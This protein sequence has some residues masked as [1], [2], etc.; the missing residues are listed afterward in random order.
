MTLEQLRIFVAVAEREHLTRAAQSLYLTQ[1]AV[2]AAIAALEAGFGVKLFDRIGRG[3]A[4][5]EAGRLFLPEARAVL[6]RAHEAEALVRDVA[7]A[8]RGSLRICASQTVGNFWLPPRL[9]RFQA[10]FPGLVLHVEHLNTE[11]AAAKVLSHEA[12]IAV[13]EGAVDDPRLSATRLNGDRMLLVLPNG[14]PAPQT[15]EDWARLKFVVREPGSGTRA[16]LAD[17]L[18]GMG[19]RL[20]ARNIALE[21]PSNEAVR[22]AVEAGAGAS[23]LS[24]LVT[25][26]AMRTGDVQGIDIGLSPRAFCALRLK[27]RAG[28]RAESEFIKVLCAG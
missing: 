3:I 21:L 23:L 6:A 7:G 10:A 24:E 25:Q 1:S 17:H 26:R 5:T 28:T 19:L 18:A 20:E 2:S 9:A 12:D 22:G 13:V 14:A 16:L 4:L 15:P 11:L 27:E 8:L